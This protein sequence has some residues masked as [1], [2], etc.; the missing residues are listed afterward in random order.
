M[1]TSTLAASRTRAPVFVVQA[2]G[3]SVLIA[4]SA[5]VSVPF[6]P[7]PMTL[8]TLAVMTIAGLFGARL[9]VAAM[10]AVLAE[11]ALGLP[12]FAGGT[13]IAVL[14]GPTAGYLAGMVAAAAIVGAAR[15]PWQRAGAIVV[16]TA[17]IYGTGVAWLSG[18]VGLDRAI[19]AGVV[20]FLAGDAAKGALAWAIA[21]VVRRRSA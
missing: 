12:V 3:L 13:G 9:G 5:H 1:T 8:Q 15:G 19:A 20:P 10:L 21:A 11:G 7:V 17:V 2:L 16:A 14:A 6:W 4:A 18:F